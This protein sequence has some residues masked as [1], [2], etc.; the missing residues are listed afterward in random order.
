MT[1]RGRGEARGAG[2]KGSGEEKGEGGVSECKESARRERRCSASG[3]ESSADEGSERTAPLRQTPL[4]STRTLFA[5][6][7]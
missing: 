5:S 3:E 6:L 2:K 1:T 4:R 7:H